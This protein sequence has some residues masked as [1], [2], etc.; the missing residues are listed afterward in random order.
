M[1]LNQNYNL[2]EPAHRPRGEVSDNFRQQDIQFENHTPRRFAQQQANPVRAQPERPRGVTRPPIPHLSG[3]LYQ[4][5]TASVRLPPLRQPIPQRVNMRDFDLYNDSVVGD[6]DGLGRAATSLETVAPEIAV[7][8]I[9]TRQLDYTKHHINSD[10]SIKNI[11]KKEFP[12]LEGP[13]NHRL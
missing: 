1:G 7:P 10:A 8:I 9:K 4:S 6:F 13:S 5:D 2:P 3:P 11:H 12:R